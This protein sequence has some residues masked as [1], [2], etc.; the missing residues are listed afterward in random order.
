METSNLLNID[1][2]TVVIRMFN[3]L[4]GTIGELREDFNKE[5]GNIYMEIEN[6]KNRNEYNRNEEYIRGNQQQIR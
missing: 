1:F 5:I 6:I 2:K 4:S 3:D